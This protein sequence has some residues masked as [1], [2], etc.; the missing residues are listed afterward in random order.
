MVCYFSGTGNSQ[1]AAKKIAEAIGDELISINLLLK[2]G[3][4]EVIHSERPLVFVAPTYAW[5]LPH[6]VEQWIRETKFEGNTKAYFILT[7]GDGCGNATKYAQALCEKKEFHFCGLASILMPENYVAR[8][9][10]P[11]Q[12]EAQAII[13]KAEPQFQDIAKHIKAGVALSGAAVSV[14][15]RLESGFVNT[16]FYALVVKDK[17]FTVSDG[18]IACGKCAERCPLNNVALS[19]SKPIWGGNCTHCMACICGCPTLAIEYK[20][21]SKG[22]SRHYIMEE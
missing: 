5:R 8:F 10:V 1:L 3:V 17:G 21:K 2:N 22:Q 18:C 12:S 4:K 16:L 13:Q 9:Q 20:N 14:L 15:G 19:S 7:C 6:V 11:R